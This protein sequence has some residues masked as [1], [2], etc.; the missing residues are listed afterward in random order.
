MLASR[1]K[2]FQKPSKHPAVGKVFR[3]VD[4][5][6]QHYALLRFH[7]ASLKVLGCQLEE[8]VFSA[9]CFYEYLI[10]KNLQFHIYLFS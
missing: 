10:F 6:A 7:V 5:C 8:Q 9:Q 3:L 2:E 4:R 1:T